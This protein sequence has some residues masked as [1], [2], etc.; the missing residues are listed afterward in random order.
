VQIAKNIILKS[1]KRVTIYDT[2][3]VTQSDLNTG[4]YFVSDDI[5][6]ISRA[7]KNLLKLKELS[8]ECTIDIYKGELAN[9]FLILKDY[10][11][12]VI[13]EL[14]SKATAESLNNFCRENKIG[15]IYCACLGL[16]GYLFTDFG[17]DYICLDEDGRKPERVKVT[18]VSN[19]NPGIVKLQKSNENHS[20]A[21]N[22]KNGDYVTFKEICGTTEL[23]DSPPRPIK[24]LSSQSV[25][26]EDTS[27]FSEYV[28]DG[29]IEKIKIPTPY[30]FRPLKDCFDTI[31]GDQYDLF[32]DLTTK[33]YTDK[34]SPGKNEKLHL[35]FLT[36]HEF[37]NQKN[38]LPYQNS[39][40]DFHII[41]SFSEQILDKAKKKKLD[42]AV[43]INNSNEIKNVLESI[44]KWSRCQ[45]APVCE[46]LGGLVA[47]EI[48]KILQLYIPFEQ[49][50]WFDFFDRIKKTSEYEWDSL[51]YEGVSKLN[52]IKLVS[53]GDKY[54]RFCEVMSRSK[55]EFSSLKKYDNSNLDQYDVVVI[56]LDLNKN[57]LEVIRN[58]FKINKLDRKL[59][60]SNLFL[61]NQVFSQVT[62][63]ENLKFQ[64]L[65]QFIE[66]IS[67][68]NNNKCLLLS[69]HCKELAANLFESI[70]NE[71]FKD[72]LALFSM[73]QKAEDQDEDEED[74]IYNH[75]DNMT[76]QILPMAS[77]QKLFN[78]KKLIEA[79][80]SK[81]Y[82]EIINYSIFK[83]IELFN[84]NIKQIILKY[85]SYEE[86]DFYYRYRRCPQSIEF[87]PN[88]K[89][90]IRF[91]ESLSLLLADILKI[92]KTEYIIEIE[93]IED[94]YTCCLF[95]LNTYN[96]NFTRNTLNSKIS[97]NETDKEIKALK[98]MIFILV[99]KNKSKVEFGS[100]PFKKDLESQ[101]KILLENTSK[102]YTS[103]NSFMVLI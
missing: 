9:D 30:G 36:V 25:T 95:S 74:L 7:E 94:I 87:N 75:L 70:F 28:S 52:P 45:V 84:F 34:I 81:K 1:P 12:V 91:V 46:F 35:A 54:P 98:E 62:Y 58:I 82:Q 96:N 63:N 60:I 76:S 103:V 18:N 8:K 80:I 53:I 6:K 65:P 97:S 51:F 49:W 90:H 37:F 57:N 66:N 101:V 43:S 71:L 42:W 27:K 39:S 64:E 55:I 77:K 26:I 17:E 33:E 83:F 23:N 86:K 32:L 92:E 3:L 56:N 59:V 22:L 47:C 11:C 15:F 41:L 102:I 79:F 100:L 85:P 10:D 67:I 13:S 50:Y 16:A 38:R 68:S 78:I 89:F 14:I 21:K 72:I 20:L 40:E 44:A 5:N 61:E 31:K 93:K 73:E 19:Q 48:M 4:T 99:Q 24:I 88:N 29:Y 2:G 69:N